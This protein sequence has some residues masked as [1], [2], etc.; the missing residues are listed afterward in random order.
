MGRFERHKQ[1][2]SPGTFPQAIDQEHMDMR[3][4]VILRA[5]IP[6][7]N[8][9]SPRMIHILKFARHIK[10]SSLPQLQRRL[11]N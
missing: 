2:L 1:V 4:E 3:A 10:D 11:M 5:T 6:P 9:R 8:S 7:R